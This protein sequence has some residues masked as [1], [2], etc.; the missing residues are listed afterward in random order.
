MTAISRPA[1]V[2][3]TGARVVTEH[4]VIVDGWA[5]VGEGRIVAVGEPGAVPPLDLV[6]LDPSAG[7]DVSPGLA[8]D[9]RGRYL[10]PGFVDLHVHGGGTATFDEGADAIGIAVS[11][12]RAHGTTRTLLSLITNSVPGMRKSISTAAGVAQRDPAIVG[13][14]LEGPFLSPS[15]RGAHDPTKLLVP[16]AAVVDSL[17]DAA[18][19]A[20]R[21]VTLA[22]ELP[23]GLDLVR[24]LVGMDVHAAV[25]H[26]DAGYDD[27]LAAFDAGADLVT[28]AF[29][30]MR[31]LHHRDP[32]VIAAAMDA[33]VV[34]ETIND[35]VHLHDATVR[36]L[37][38][39]APHRLAF[40]TDAMAAAG[41]VDGRYRL[42]PLEVEVSGGTARLVE[43]GTIAG[44]TLTM[45]VAVRRGVLDVGMDVVD[46]VAAASV[47][48]ARWLGRDA[49][50]GSI[51]VGR[52]A[53]LVVMDDDLVTV[54]VM[55]DGCWV[56]DRRP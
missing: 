5:L 54:A 31:P 44:S 39:V 47:V 3:F 21:V 42:G 33:G 24:R 12:H 17:L 43:G 26:T 9:V 8:V 1:P 15:H 4:R 55:A 22:P 18:G 45:D 14:H 11:T 50:F 6:G 52:A 30:A 10:M 38:R 23:G 35:G 51:A 2:L 7:L 34:L 46:A 37:H 32:G 25:G 40:V 29:N 41:A 56:D 27:A 19:G 48:P 28:H 16:D 13:L 49:E 36:L 20:V 53:D